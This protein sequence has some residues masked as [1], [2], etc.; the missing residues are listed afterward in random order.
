M[1]NGIYVKTITNV[2]IQENG[3]IRNSDGLLIGHL[4]SDTNFKSKD[5]NDHDNIK[6]SMKILSNEMKDTGLGSYAHSWRCNIAMSCYDSIMGFD[7]QI[8]WAHTI[9][10]EAASR[11]MSLC[12]DVETSNDS[13]IVD[14]EM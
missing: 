1:N 2:M 13:A 4:T 11:F 3:I 6:N 7:D 9:S 8:D 5:I 12:F 14:K 10:N